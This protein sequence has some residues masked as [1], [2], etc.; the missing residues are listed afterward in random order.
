MKSLLFLAST[1]SLAACATNPRP[2]IAGETGSNLAR[3]IAAADSLVENA[4]GTL[5]PG[6]VLVISKDGKVIHERAFGYASL[7]D[8]EMHRLANPVA[9]KTTT[10]FDLAS[11]TKVMATTFAVMMLVDRGKIDVDAPVYRYLPDFRGPHLDSITVRHL[12]QHSSGLVQWQPLYYQASNSAETYKAIR[13][14]PLQW[15]VGQGRHYSDLGFMLLGYIV[16]KVSGTPLDQFVDAELYRPL[17]LTH[18][19]FNPKKKGFAEFAATEQG[20]VYEKHMVYDSTF[21]YRYRGDPTSWNKWRSEILFGET[22][23]GNSYYANGGVAGHAGLFSTAG[24]LRVLLDLLVNRGSY[25]GR[26]YIDSGV[27]ARF[28]TVDKYGHYLGWQ[29]PQDMPEGSFMHTGFTGTYVLGIPEHKLSV[30]LLTNRQNLGTDAKGFFPDVGPLRIAVGKAILAGV[31]LPIA[32]HFEPVDFSA[33]RWLKGNTHTHTLE[34]DGD[35]PPD[36]VAAWYKRHGYNFLVLSDHNVW[37]DP[38]RFA[39]LFDSTYML[40]P[41]EELTTR[42]GQ[43]PV[44][45]NGLNIPGVIP[46]ETDSTLLGTVQKNVDAVRRAEGVPHINHPN[47]GWA[48]SEDVLWKVN[49]DKLVEIHN[50][51]P[52]VHNE[53]GGDSPGMEMVWDYLLTKGK[54]IYGIAVDDAHHFKGEFAADRANPG[55]GWVVVRAGRLDPREIMTSLEAGRFYASSG[56]EL[57]SLS[58]TS[59]QMLI[60]I[61]RRGDFK[62]TTEFI[63]RDGAVLRKTGANPAVY[64]LKGGESYVR[65]VVTNSGGEKA[66]IQPVFVTR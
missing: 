5:A 64:R 16:E 58:V 26:Q 44:H 40:I 60:A 27:I 53:G 63:G 51:H 56:V 1:I 8:Y 52:L 12:L 48:I 23:D 65:A 38:A 30:V 29:F 54:R 62:F 49:N 35:S 42:F 22:D 10:M 28:F 33:G 31:E 6:A 34:S 13:E 57:D 2:A 18:T 59:R 9:M 19:T 3:A 32:E 7:N 24:E 41:G 39:Y 61:K 14:M 36:T 17:G 50:G 4:M 47:F 21:G 20:N 55:R 43:K 37:V 46:P 45:V 25:N 66:W 11:V 15:G